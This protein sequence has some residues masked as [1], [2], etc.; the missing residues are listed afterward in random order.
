M[1]TVNPS[2]RHFIISDK[3]EAGVAL[4]GGEVKSV[5]KQGV[6]LKEAFVQIREGEAYLVNAHIAQYQ[7]VKDRPYDP[8]R[9]RK[10][11]LNKKE[12]AKLISKK[13]QGLAIIPLLCYN[14]AG[15][16]KLQ[17]GVGKKKRKIDKK[18]EMIEKDQKK[19]TR[20]F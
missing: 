10:L 18:R 19:A 15:W 2:T 11:L 9:S 12:L 7:Y 14:K 1:K 3:F 8:T 20:S 16:I 4:T 6:I 13:K 17:I 5:K